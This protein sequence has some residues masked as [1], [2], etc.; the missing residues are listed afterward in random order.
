MVSGQNGTS[1]RSAVIATLHQH[2]LARH[3][4]AQL[5]MLSRTML[6][7][8]RRRGRE[9]AAMLDAESGR[10]V[11]TVISG[12]EDYVDLRPHISMFIKNRQYVQF[13]TH[14][15][16]S[17]F[18]DADVATLLSWNQIHVMV[19]AGVDG[20]WYALSRLGPTRLSAVEAAEALLAEMDRLQEER[21][22][23]SLREC[24]HLAWIAIAHRLGLR[25]D[26]VQRDEQ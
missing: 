8:T 11:G 16:S 24:T 26:R 19:V 5:W 2:G 6:P 23:S 13:H 1:L 7:T 10:M 14:P 20:T 22:D 17:S 25:Y 12:G 21:P 3:V 15:G 9:Y 18:S 4:G